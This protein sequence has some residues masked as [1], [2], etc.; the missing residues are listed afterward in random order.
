MSSTTLRLELP[1]MFNFFRQK[2]LDKRDFFTAPP[3]TLHFAASFILWVN[4]AVL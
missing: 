1:S 4:V 3:K 2:L